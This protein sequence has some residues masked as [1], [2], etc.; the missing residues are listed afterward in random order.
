M[1]KFLSLLLLLNSVTSTADR[2]PKRQP[3]FLTST[4]S[5]VIV[6]IP[7]M[8]LSPLSAPTSDTSGFTT[9]HREKKGENSNRKNRTSETLENF[10]TLLAEGHELTKKQ[11]GPLSLTTLNMLDSE[12]L[13]LAGVILLLKNELPSET[14]PAA[15]LKPSSSFVDSSDKELT[16]CEA[17]SDL[18]SSY[19]Q[20][21][22]DR[23]ANIFGLSHEFSTPIQV[24]SSR[25]ASA[26]PSFQN[27]KPFHSNHF[28]RAL[29]VS[30][31]SSAP[32]R[33]KEEQLH[34]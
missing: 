26:N 15:A 32:A 29:V 8:P 21:G 20:I 7:K 3:P 17:D 13:R 28:A 27:R 34:Q 31:P 25:S 16:G 6:P 19:D 11:F 30:R 5:G 2:K 4:P 9:P 14:N 10:F 12:M 18:S 22:D 24:I 1:K 33:D 23:S